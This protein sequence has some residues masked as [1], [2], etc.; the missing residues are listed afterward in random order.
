[1]L[2]YLKTQGEVTAVCFLSDS[3][4]WREVRQTVG[5]RNN[6]CYQ[7]YHLHSSHNMFIWWF[8][9][10]GFQILTVSLQVHS[11]KGWKLVNLFSKTHIKPAVSIYFYLQFCFST[12]LFDWLARDTTNLLDSF[13]QVKEKL[14]HWLS[15]STVLLSSQ[16]PSLIH[17][18]VDVLAQLVHWTG[19]HTV[20]KHPAL[21]WWQPDHYVCP[22]H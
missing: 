14:T 20:G 15:D 4:A 3:P 22:F 18:T 21:S 10:P 9:I 1:M 7:A 2:T 16:V 5:G 12:F 19:H 13:Q 8:F 11:S 17:K 6:Y